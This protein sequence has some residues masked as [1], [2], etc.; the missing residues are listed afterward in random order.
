MRRTMPNLILRHY[1]M[2]SF[3]EKVHVVQVHF[4]R[5][6]DALNQELTT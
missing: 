3:S 1:A 4:A 5:L 2:S 6:G